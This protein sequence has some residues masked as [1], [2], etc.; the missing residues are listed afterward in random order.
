MAK[1]ETRV[2]EILGTDYHIHFH[3]LSSGHIKHATFKC[4]FNHM[5]NAYYLLIWKDIILIMW[6][7]LVKNVK[8]QNCFCDIIL[9]VYNMYRK[10]P[11]NIKLILVLSGAEIIDFF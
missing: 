10:K 5:G 3:I 8:M 9:I 4:G 6:K 7:T 2:P 11:Y 1:Q